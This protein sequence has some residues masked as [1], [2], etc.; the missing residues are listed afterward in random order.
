VSELNVRRTASQWPRVYYHPASDASRKVLLTAAHLQIALDLQIV[1]AGSLAHQQPDYLQLNPNGLFPVLIDGD[2]VLWEATAIVQYLA[3]KEPADALWPDDSR[4]RAD[5]VRWQC[6]DLAHW[7]PALRPFIWERFG[8]KLK[9]LGDPDRRELDKAATVFARFT[10]VLNNHLATRPWLVGGSV[11]LADLCVGSHFMFR[12]VAKF[13]L[14]RCGH[15]NRW[16]ARIEALPC[17]R[18]TRPPIPGLL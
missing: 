12:D 7:G 11:T 4:L 10:D 1:D 14:D 2:F 13:P 5:I 16:F 3:A 8:K 17:W 15:V 18:N 6:W 9:G